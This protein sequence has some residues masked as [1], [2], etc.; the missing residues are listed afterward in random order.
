[1]ATIPSDPLFSNQWHLRN[2][3]PGLLD[4]N[5][6]DVWDDYTGAGVQVAVIDDAV[7]RTHPDL[8]GNYSVAKDWDFRDN[9][10]DPSGLSSDRHGTA[11]AGIIGA[12]EGNGIGG[13]G[14]AYD[15]TIFGFGI[16]Y[17]NTLVQ[18]AT[19]AINNA[20]GLEQKLGI[21]READV[22]NMSF[23]TYSY[24]DVGRD[25]AQM[26]ALN[27]AIDNAA[28]FG[29]DG[30]GTILVKSAGNRRSSNFD[31]NAMSWNANPHTISVAAVDQNGFVS[32]YSSHGASVLVSAFGTPGQVVTTDRTGSAGYKSGDYT[33]TFNGTS[34]ATPMVSG[35]VA[36]M[37]EANP[38]LGW[39]D[40]QEILAYSARHVGSNVGSDTRG[41]EEYAWSFNGANNWN[42]GGL[43][44][45]ND[46]GFGL[47]D[48]KAAVRLAETWGSNSQTSAN[49]TT[50]FRDFLNTSTTISSGIS[51]TSFSQFINS[52]IEIEHVE[53][54][55][56]FTQWHDLGDLELRLLSPDGTSSILIDNSGE[57]NGS[58]TGGFGSG[59]WE[60]FSN[61][62]RGE[63]TLGTWTVQFFDTDSNTISPITVNDI[64]IT[65]Y[66]QAASN[67]DTFIF[68]EEYS[69][70]EYSN[71]DGLF[72]HR[73]SINGGIGTDTINAAAVDS[74]STVN[75]TTGTG[76]IDDVA[77][78]V[79]GIENVFTGDGN[80][81]LFGNASNNSLSGMRGN[82]YLYGYAGNDYL[83][84]GT[85]SDR[86]YG[87]TGNDRFVVD[88]TGDV[89]V[90]YA[91]QGSDRVYSSISYTLGNNLESLTLTGT[92][93]SGRG[94][95][96]NNSISGNSSN[97]YLYGY[98]G[99]DYLLG[100]AGN[101][102][103]SGSSGNDY[104]N[105]GTGSD[106]MYG[107]TG[108]DTLSGSSGNDYLNG[109]TGSDRM[110]GG[111]G[112]DRFV[113]DSTG[114]TVTEYANQGSDRVY[115]SIS[116]TLGNNLENL[117]LTGTASSGRGN[118]LNNSI[119]GNSSNNYLYGQGG[120]DTLIGGSGNDYL[121]SD[122]LGAVDTIG[123]R[124]DGGDGNDTLQGEAGNDILL[125]GSGNDRLTGDDSSSNFGDDNLAGGTG[126]DTLTGAGGNDTLVGGSGSD[127]L[128]GTNS[129]LDGAGEIDIINPGDYGASDRIILGTSSSIYYNGAGLDYAVIDDFDRYSYFGETDFDKLQ[130]HGSLSSYSLSSY[131]GT[132]SG[133]SMNN[134]TR[135]GLGSE[136]IAYVDSSGLLTSAD[137]ITV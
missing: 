22:V 8:D 60:F 87:G 18:R 88:S 123:D 71:Y 83:S 36:L 12:N 51:G 16:N 70:E 115:S 86:M 6:V 113:V 28:I 38:N 50:V 56:N 105:G 132:V 54:D 136:I 99:N 30:L 61:Q 128:S 20:S 34:A 75:L 108:N 68:T 19:E 89:V 23:S 127:T 69:N 125:G 118:S 116:Y 90:E 53:V 94:N 79:S 92:A 133:I 91:N 117:T 9:D 76:S 52:N 131:T 59:R 124:L 37:L 74:N 112:N 58:S 97:N 106:R 122:T 15:A 104:L 110:Y 100:Y 4:L 25:S 126:N 130:I 31:T 109:G 33:S 78:T 57:N 107:G 48:A 47:V 119:S 46:Y 64:D 49:D 42:G 26:A 44:F 102:Y 114:D 55:V 45:S 111:T 65:F 63:D 73:T 21:N 24:F 17:D 40:V 80:D 43:H 41:S 7:Q 39:R 82:D 103:L 67:N 29:R 62:F 121:D 14:V 95:S 135:I 66:G 32:S 1:M 77:I 27:T 120:A 129:I 13:V 10:T 85:G 134:G 35:V 11:V 81:S 72:G 3:T 98:A 137:F 96:L 5:V 101:D 93:S 2:T 84:G